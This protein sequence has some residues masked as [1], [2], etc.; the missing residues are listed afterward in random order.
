MIYKI[1]KN[2]FYSIWYKRFVPWF[3]N[4]VSFTCIFLDETKG[5]TDDFKDTSKII[6][7]SNGW[8]HKIYCMGIG[9]R[10]NEDT[11]MFELRYMGY[12]NGENFTGLLIEHY[13]QFN[14]TGS[15]IKRNK[16]W[17]IDIQPID[18]IDAKIKLISTESTWFGY[19]YLTTPQIGGDTPANWDFKIKLFIN[20]KQMKNW[21][22][23][24]YY[25][26]SVL[27]I[28]LSIYAIFY[29]GGMGNIIFGIIAFIV[30]VSMLFFDTLCENDEDHT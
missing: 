30:G 9:F 2:N 10:F 3:N 18:E 26:V 20:R 25:V 27:I 23:I 21:M 17:V 7:L 5:I 13:K 14:F 12:E 24:L 6:R 11:N 4:K 8:Y 29:I 28:L 22:K 16:Y 15:I 19:R 1:K